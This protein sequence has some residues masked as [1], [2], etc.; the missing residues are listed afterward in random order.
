MLRVDA[1]GKQAIG[2]TAIGATTS[3][4][5]FLNATPLDVSSTNTELTPV[6]RRRGITR[7]EPTRRGH[8]NT[9]TLVTPNVRFPVPN[10]LTANN[11]R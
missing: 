9:A 5:M 1:D 10:Y 6:S 2:P 7:F 3:S 8:R 11:E 4:A